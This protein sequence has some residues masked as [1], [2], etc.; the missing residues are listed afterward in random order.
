MSANELALAV[1]DAFEKAGIP[2][3]IVG[4]FSSNMYGLP[5]STLDADFVV[6]LGHRTAQVLMPFLGSDFILDS[7]MSFETVTATSRYNIVHPRT[8]FKIELFLLH[9]ND[10]YDQL[11]FSRRR[12]GHLDGR[13]VF[14][15]SPEDVIVTK[16]LW[17][18]RGSRQKD[19]DDIR[20]VLIVMPPETLDLPYILHWTTQHG[21][22]EAFE[23]LRQQA[24]QIRLSAGTES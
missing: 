6:Q 7:Q 8:K 23:S 10:P 11:R 13:P 22:R 19:M 20:N 15:P 9:E 17:G 5:R 21:T 2:Y 1:V 18:K 12:L 24:A 16:L 14:A 3:M 4:S